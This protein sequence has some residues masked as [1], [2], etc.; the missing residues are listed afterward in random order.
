M[1]KEVNYI[2]ISNLGPQ[3]YNNVGGSMLGGAC[4]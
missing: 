1:T 2:L 4:T 3:D